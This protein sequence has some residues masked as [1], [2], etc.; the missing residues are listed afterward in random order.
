LEVKVEFIGAI[1]LLLLIIFLGS[2][3]LSRR[4]SS[5]TLQDWA[6]IVTVASGIALVITGIFYGCNVNRAAET[7]EASQTS[8]Q[9][10]AFAN[11]TEHPT[12]VPIDTSTGTS[13]LTATEAGTFTDPPTAT[14]TI[15]PDYLA[16]RGLSADCFDI[17][18]WTPKDEVALFTRDKPCWPLE[19]VS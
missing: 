2:A 18:Y 17:R 1:I 8:T 19:S 7:P 15:H 12:S 13:V 16:S 14:A 5:S 3:Y 11:S 10:A 9:T 6:N 4:L